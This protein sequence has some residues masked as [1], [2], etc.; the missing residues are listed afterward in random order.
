MLQV[1]E[2]ETQISS[3]LPVTHALLKAGKL[4]VHD[5]V[6]RITLHGSRG[7]AGC[8]RSDSDVDLSLLADTG[9]CTRVPE[10]EALLETILRTTADTWRGDIELD[11]AIVFDVRGCGLKCFKH[12]AFDPGECPQG[13]VDCFG[14]YKKG[15]GFDGLVTNAGVKVRLMYPCI[16]IWHKG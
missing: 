3:L 5:Q 13:G 10:L 6:M 8:Y 12:M 11:L 14:L 16:T 4:K 1:T 7:L 9:N 2:F 15:H